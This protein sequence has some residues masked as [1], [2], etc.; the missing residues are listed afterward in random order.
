MED[1]AIDLFIFLFAV[2]KEQKFRA[3]IFGLALSQQNSFL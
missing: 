2:R 1:F 3:E